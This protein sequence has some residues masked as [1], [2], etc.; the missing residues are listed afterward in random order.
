MIGRQPGEFRGPGRSAAGRRGR[1]ESGAALVEFALVFSLFVFVLY[2]LISFA[3]MLALKQSITSAA[4]DGARA[5]VGAVPASGE[6][7]DDAQV[8]VATDRVNG[9]LGWLGGRY[10]PAS[11][12]AVPRPTWC[13]GSSGPK[14]ITVTVSYPY[15][16]RPL[17]PPAPIF[18]AMA[19]ETIQTTAVVQVNS[20]QLTS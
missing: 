16:Q 7:L 6:T 19:P 13:S 4:A 14:C 8:R 3:M 5:A 11:D 18:N 1:G 2:G 15:R 20:S 9:A 12:L 17:V 10:V